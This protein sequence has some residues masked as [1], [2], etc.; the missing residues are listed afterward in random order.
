M[1]SRIRF[2]FYSGSGSDPFTFLFWTRSYKFDLETDPLTDLDPD[3]L[4]SFCSRSRHPTNKEDGSDP[5]VCEK[6]QKCKIICFSDLS[7]PPLNVD[8]STVTRRTTSV[9]SNERK[10]RQTE[11]R[12]SSLWHLSYLQQRQRYNLLGAK[13]MTEHPPPSC[14]QLSRK[15]YLYAPLSCTVQ[16]IK[17]RRNTD[18]VP[19]V[20]LPSLKQI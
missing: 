6:K 11:G 18:W 5:K 3:S 16:Y 7:A 13:P 4:T 20:Y 1:N 17:Y 14:K 15:R 10:F 8:R 9:S 12:T 19:T 2:L